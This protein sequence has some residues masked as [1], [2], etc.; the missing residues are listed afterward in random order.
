MKNYR[1]QIRL[2]A[3]TVLLILVTAFCMK[4]TVKSQRNEDRG[5]QNKYYATLEKEYINALRNELCRQGYM[6]SGITV[7]WTAEED[8]TRCYIV[9][10]HHNRIND[11]NESGQMALLRT[12]SEKEF[13]D[14][15]CRFYY[16]FITT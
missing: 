15:S 16:E 4:E 11:L 10:I 14:A 8:D 12:L 7:R 2:L 13:K 6:N 5:V 1:K 3:V 9:M